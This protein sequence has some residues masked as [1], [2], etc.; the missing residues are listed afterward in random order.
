LW[1]FASSCGFNR[2]KKEKSSGRRLAPSSK[3]SGSAN[4]QV[5]K[6]GEPVKV[7]CVRERKRGSWVGERTN[8][9]RREE[10][11]RVQDVASQAVHA[12]RTRGGGDIG[13][14]DG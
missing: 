6:S 2:L 11:R 1:S 4:Q 10:K 8:E 7:A 12:Q 14:E 3:V 13:R 5:F 9:K